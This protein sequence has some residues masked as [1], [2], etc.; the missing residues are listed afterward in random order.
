LFVNLQREKED[1]MFLETFC[2]LC[3]IFTVGYFIITPA[4]GAWDKLPSTPNMEGYVVKLGNDGLSY[5]LCKRTKSGRIIRCANV[6]FGFRNE[7]LSLDRE[8][9]NFVA[10]IRRMGFPGMGYELR[11][12]SVR[13]GELKEL[14]TKIEKIFQNWEREAS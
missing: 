8:D 14:A 5:D 1:T 13:A 2:I 10:Q 12:C 3:L 4:R 11:R 7:V 9:G 6:K